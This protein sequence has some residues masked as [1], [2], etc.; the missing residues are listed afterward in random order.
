MKAPFL[1]GR[2]WNTTMKC[3]NDVSS[4]AKTKLHRL[5]KAILWLIFIT[6]LASCVSEPLARNSV[7]VALFLSAVRLFADR[8]VLCELSGF[9]SLW[10]AMA[11]MLSLLAISCVYGDN[12]AELTKNGYFRCN[13][14]MLIVPLI[15]LFVRDTKN[16]RRLLLC[17]ALSLIAADC[18]VFWQWSEGYSRPTSW[19]RA[20]FMLTGMFYCLILPILTAFAI[21][22]REQPRTRRLAAFLTVFSF[23]ALILTGTRAAI[24]ASVIACPCLVTA[25]A[26]NRAKTLL[27]L[28]G[29]GIVLAAAA[30]SYPQT[31]ARLQTILDMNYQSNSERILVWRSALK[32]FAD[33]PLL[34]VGYGNF[35][36]VYDASYVSPESVEDIKH[37]H[38][39][40]LQS[41]VET[42][43]IGFAAYLWLLFNI[44][45]VLFKNRKRHI[46]IEAILWSFV[47]ILLF[48]ATDYSWVGFSG[49]RILWILLGAA[50]AAERLTSS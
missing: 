3:G 10:A 23:V 5:D 34:G 13:C 38:N 47:A 7:R 15:V 24:I 48:G 33:H 29:V 6:A 11:A 17:V 12:A 26:K 37:T 30:I 8:T 45:A 46:Y 21:N 4:A 1:T 49:M 31:N 42:G 2:E 35:K 19:I 25:V 22:E 43:L 20:S 27:A 18:H 32:M 14:Y 44:F 41:L 16:L 9:R 39:N 40:Y 28:F 36:T 50:L